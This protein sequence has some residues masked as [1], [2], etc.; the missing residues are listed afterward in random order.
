MTLAIH[1]VW[2]AIRRSWVARILKMVVAILLELLH[3]TSW[4]LVL[5][6]DLGP[7]LVADGWELNGTRAALLVAWG[8]R[9][10]LAGRLAFHRS[11]ANSSSSAFLVGL[12]LILLVLL[13]RLPLLADFL[14]LCK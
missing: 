4:G 8:C 1:L 5:A 2:S 11:T 7:G 13:A 3:T 9:R 14:E 6:R 12:A 10:S